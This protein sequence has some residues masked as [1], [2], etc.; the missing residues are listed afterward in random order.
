MIVLACWSIE[1]IMGALNALRT[2]IV[3]V[4]WKS[5]TLRLVTSK[6]WLTVA[7]ML[8]LVTNSSNG[9]SRLA[10]MSEGAGKF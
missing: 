9:R 6:I 10:G 7:W 4:F 2:N 5:P 1:R 8:C 3:R